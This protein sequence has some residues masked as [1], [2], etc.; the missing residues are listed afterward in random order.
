MA[1]EAAKN[2][3]EALMESKKRG[4]DDDGEDRAAK[5]QKTD[6]SGVEK[7]ES[8]F[9]E[10]PS[11]KREGD[12]RDRR[13]KSS[14]SGSRKRDRKRR[15]RRRRRR[16]PSRSN[17][18]LDDGVDHGPGL[19][20][21]RRGERRHRNLWDVDPD[22]AESL[23]LL[24]GLPINVD[25]KGDFMHADRASRRIYVGNLPLNVKESE[26]RDFFNCVMV[27]AQ[28][29]GRKAGDSV[30]GV[31][32]NLAKR[33]AFVEF[34][35]AVEATQAMDLDGIMFRGLALKMGR[36]ANYN[37][38]ASSI[39]ARQAPKLNIAKL[40]ILSSHVPNGPNKLYIGGLP[41]NLKEPQVRELLETYG[42]LR[43]L[44]LSFDPATNLSKGYAFA[45]YEDESITDAAIEGLNGLQIGDRTLAVRRH[46]S[47]AQ[48]QKPQQML[49]TIT[50]DN[51]QEATDCICMLQMITTDDL[52]DK[53]EV[54][55]I[56]A[57]IRNECSNFGEVIEIIIP[58]YGPDAKLMPG[59]GK[60]FVQFRT[61]EQAGACKKALQ[62]R[63]FADRT[64]IVTFFDPVKFKARDFL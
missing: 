44:F 2:A 9:K 8:T 52:N 41:Y 45:Y 36:P 25:G 58:T 29:P 35:S 18:P 55:D 57:D 1:E 15:R 23:G 10:E 17:S 32:L 16:S 43:G 27:A 28:G 24:T 54:L 37:P 40:G 3:F 46:E 39:A 62:G 33:F 34:R 30:L 64:V 11:V 12:D 38:S 50:K 60:V 59:A 49:N 53:D 5:R 6:D 19:R 4:N 7:T 13:R 63:T 21:R 31:F 48:F 56:T 47:C 20:P 14:R 26:I 22:I 61:I 42:P 51:K